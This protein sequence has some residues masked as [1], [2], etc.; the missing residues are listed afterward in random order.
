M[1]FFIGGWRRAL[2]RS[3]LEWC[4]GCRRNSSEPRRNRADVDRVPTTRLCGIHGSG[5]SWTEV[6]SGTRRWRAEC[7]SRGSPC[8]SCRG[9]DVSQRPSWVGG[10]VR[11]SGSG[12]KKALS[13]IGG[14]QEGGRGR[15]ERGSPFVGHAMAPGESAFVRWS[16]LSCGRFVEALVCLLTWDFD[17]EKVEPPNWLPRAQ[18]R[19][20]LKPRMTESQRL[21]MS[22]TGRVS[23]IATHLP[24][25][26][27]GLF[28]PACE[29]S[30]RN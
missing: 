28:C 12:W 25:C 20:S 30:R 15:L 7:G 4:C 29:E 1:V 3:A 14:L 22:F 27:T 19:D 2:L 5:T 9:C 26:R 17:H 16:V 13:A 24:N 8:L 23:S 21:H 11:C 6:K 18:A 10:R